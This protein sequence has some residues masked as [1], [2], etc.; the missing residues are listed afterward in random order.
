MSGP[1]GG[2]GPGRLVAVEGI[3]GCG[4]ST[5]ARLLAEA[6]GARLTFEPGGTRL[7]QVLRAVMLGDHRIALSERAEALLMVADRAQHVAELIEPAMA[8]GRWV[9]TD[10]FSGSTLAYQGSG[11]G[12]DVTALRGLVDWGAGGRWPD[13]SVLVDVPPEVARDRMAASS[14]DRL[15]RLE[16]DF[17]RRVREGFLRQASEDPRTWLVVDGSGTVDRVAAAV[18]QGVRERLGWPVGAVPS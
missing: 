8:A 5:Q 11:R 10:R 18:A 15:E 16:P 7:G 3:D 12:L 6:T 4:K 2:G 13:L 17:H 14:P 9:V 1:P